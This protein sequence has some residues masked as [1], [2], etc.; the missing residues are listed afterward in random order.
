MLHSIDS[1]AAGGQYVTHID[2]P[3][4]VSTQS[5]QYE[6]NLRAIRF[7]ATQEELACILC[8]QLLCCSHDFCCRLHLAPISR[9]S[10][11]V[12]HRSLLIELLNVSAGRMGF[13]QPVYHIS[14]N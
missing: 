14:A 11:L 13:T 6:K 2:I 12:K 4:A 10:R 9:S 5:V 1:Y 3:A 7:P 8:C